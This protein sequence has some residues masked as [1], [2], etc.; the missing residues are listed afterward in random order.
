MI[1]IENTIYQ[2]GKNEIFFHYFEILYLKKLKKTE[3]ERQREVML[4]KKKKVE[5]CLGGTV[6]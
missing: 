3:G 1:L 2:Q 6:G 5:G 4:F